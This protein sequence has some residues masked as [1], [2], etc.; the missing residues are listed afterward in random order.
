MNFKRKSAILK[1]ETL[2]TPALGSFT[3]D[4][5]KECSPALTFTRYAIILTGVI[6][7]F[8]IL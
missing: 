3:V 2:K 8:I 5:V 6:K 1:K 7:R 4:N